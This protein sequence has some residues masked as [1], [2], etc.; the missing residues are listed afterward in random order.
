MN[1]GSR[2]I[3][4]TS[5]IAALSMVVYSQ[6][7]ALDVGRT[8]PEAL[9]WTKLPSGLARANVVG[10]DKQP[11]IYSYRIKFPAGFKLQPHFH[12]D[13][14]VVTVMSG[15]M[16]IGTG[17]QF[18]EGTVTRLPEGSVF[19]E[20]AKQPHYNW[21]KDGEVIVQIVGHGPSATTQVKK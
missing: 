2:R 3:A 5:I 14:R 10:N 16:Y 6:V 7:V 8:T 13:D 15:T 21:A 1:K 9:Q 20:P 12:A 11:G 17:E 18:D 19:T 4:C